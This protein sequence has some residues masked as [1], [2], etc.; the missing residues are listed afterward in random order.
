MAKQRTPEITTK[1][2]SSIPSKNT[3]PELALRRALF[4]KGLRF[5]VNYKALKGHPDIVFTKAR[6]AVFVDGD[7]WHGHNW[8]LR[9]YSNLDDELSHYS[10]YWVT[11]IR[12]N[13]ERDQIVNDALKEDGWLVIRIW[14]SNIKNDLNTCCQMLFDQY[15]KRM[16]GTIGDKR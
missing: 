15:Q 14:E 2:M 10:D 13:V 9:G 6:M 12:K 3:A 1:I 8:A 7:F 16:S 4:A 5:R 11:K